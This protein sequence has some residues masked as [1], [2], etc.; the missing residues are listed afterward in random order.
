MESKEWQACRNRRKSVS[1]SFT[2]VERCSVWAW[3]DGIDKVHTLYGYKVTE[4]RIHAHSTSRSCCS[5]RRM[6]LSGFVY[7]CVE[8]VTML[9]SVT[10]KQIFYVLIISCIVWYCSCPYSCRCHSQTKSVWLQL[11]LALCVLTWVFAIPEEAIFASK[12]NSCTEVS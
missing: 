3:D 10:W 9:H 11:H 8:S 6:Q 4:T 5:V 2:R 7:L 12:L 1:L